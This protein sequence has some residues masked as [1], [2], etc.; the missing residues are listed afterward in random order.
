MGITWWRWRMGASIYPEERSDEGSGAIRA[1]VACRGVLFQWHVQVR[2]P[3]P[4][5]FCGERETRSAGE[6]RFLIAQLAQ[7]PPPHPPSAP[8]PPQKP[9]GRRPLDVRSDSLLLH[10]CACAVNQ[11]RI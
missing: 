2:V 9:R 1:K 8:S 3:L 10:Q 5:S 4:A 11:L 7:A 6:G